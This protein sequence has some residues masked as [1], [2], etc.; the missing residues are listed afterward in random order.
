[1]KVHNAENTLAWL[2]S[3]FSRN[4]Q[5]NIGRLLRLEELDRRFDD[6]TLNLRA[7]ER[8]TAR[9]LVQNNIQ[10]V[11]ESLIEALKVAYGL[12]TDQTGSIAPTKVPKEHLVSLNP[13]LRPRL[14]TGDTFAEALRKMFAQ[15]LL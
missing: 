1:Q 14:S 13:Q 3:F 9:K 4:V 7:D 6:Y 15:A 12:Y 11:R 10:T 2:P 8:P 5:N